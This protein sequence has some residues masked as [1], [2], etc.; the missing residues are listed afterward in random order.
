MSRLLP[1]TN[2]TLVWN[3]STLPPGHIPGS[4]FHPSIVAVYDILSDYRG[5]TNA[6]RSD[7]DRHVRC[8]ESQQAVCQQAVQACHSSMHP[9]YA[10]L[11]ERL[12]W[13]NRELDD[14][15]EAYRLDPNGSSSYWK[16]AAHMLRTTVYATNHPD[17]YALL[18]G[19]AGLPGLTFDP[20]LHPYQTQ[21]QTRVMNSGRVGD[22]FYHQ[23]VNYVQYPV[24]L[25][26]RNPRN[27]PIEGPL[28]A[29]VNMPVTEPV[30]MNS[31]EQNQ[32]AIGVAEVEVT[33]EPSMV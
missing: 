16:R 21:S 28:H 8:L 11:L 33:T 31:D 29:T 9:R 25:V 10:S 24:N 22:V 14:A 6:T 1:P 19:A 23:P 2:N 18:S 17:P 5:V 20:P 3:G 27:I 15:R 32:V 26:Q 30:R 7:I 12:A 13:I 4:S